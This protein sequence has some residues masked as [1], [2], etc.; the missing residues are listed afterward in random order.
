V[1]HDRPPFVPRAR[2]RH[3]EAGAPRQ[4]ATAGRSLHPILGVVT[5]LP[6]RQATSRS[7]AVGCAH[8]HLRKLPESRLPPVAE[9]L[10]RAGALPRAMPHVPVFPATSRCRRDAAVR[11]DRRA[12]ASSDDAGRSIPHATWRPLRRSATE[13]V[14]DGSEHDTS[15]GRRP[16]SLPNPM[17]ARVSCGKAGRTTSCTASG[18]ARRPTGNA[19]RRRNECPAGAAAPM[20]RCQPARRGR[21][22][23]RRRWPSAAAAQDLTQLLA[24]SGR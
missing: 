2:P 19:L 3:G 15:Q 5:T 18:L 9:R 8:R 4:L 22:P 13:R 7:C 17:A 23:L 21:R 20:L 16:F 11:R 24:G 1:F 10:M 6:S 14:E 12:S